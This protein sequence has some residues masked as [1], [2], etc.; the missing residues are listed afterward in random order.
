MRQPVKHARAA[1]ILFLCLLLLS[2]LGA[3]GAV[4]A[5]APPQTAASAPAVI[6]IG[7]GS[8]VGTDACLNAAGPIG[9]NSCNGDA[10][11][12]NTAGSIGDNS[13]NGD[14]SCGNATGNIGDNSCNSGGTYVC[15]DTTGNIGS[16]SCNETNACVQHKGNIGDNSCNAGGNACSFGTGPIGN[17]SCYEWQSCS[18]AKTVG[19]YSCRGFGACTS[20]TADIGSYSCNGYQ[21][22]LGN[23]STVGDCENNAVHCRQPD[24]RIRRSGGELWGN[25]VYDPEGN[26]VDQYVS[27]KIYAGDVRRVYISV[28]NDGLVPQSLSICQCQSAFAFGALV[29]YFRGDHEITT[30][31]RNNTF[32]TPTLDPGDKYVIRARV[33]IDS[34]APKGFLNWFEVWATSSV[35]GTTS[36]RVTIWVQRK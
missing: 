32:A 3:T 9:D 12:K 28:Q 15:A 4:A 24:A 11:C 1:G 33:A 10:A 35:D 19:D 30:E 34:N 13:C 26:G 14:A 29:R 27:M 6:V 31:V 17:N 18:G 22:C 21:I 20:S 8:C 23:T 25:N 36:D 7:S 2:S 16:G 5:P